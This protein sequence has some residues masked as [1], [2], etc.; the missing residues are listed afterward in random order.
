MEIL[1]SMRKE[2]IALARNHGA[3]NIIVLG[4]VSRKKRP[5]IHSA[6]LEYA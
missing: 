6:S 5:L 2:L 1:E 3:S 4:S